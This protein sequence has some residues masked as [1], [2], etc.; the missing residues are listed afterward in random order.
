MRTKQQPGVEELFV[1]PN[2][3]S[4]FLIFEFKTEL[5]SLAEIRIYNTSGIL[6]QKSPSIYLPYGSSQYRLE[7]EGARTSGLFLY[8]ISMGNWTLYSGRFIRL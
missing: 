3:A 8:Q 7:F 1:Y 5:E 4:E 2:P 6:V